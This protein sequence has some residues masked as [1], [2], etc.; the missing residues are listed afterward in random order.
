MF[1]DWRVLAHIP[2]ISHSYSTHLP[3]I[4]HSYK[5]NDWGSPGVTT[6][7][8]SKPWWLQT[9]T[10]VAPDI[11]SRFSMGWSMGW[12]DSRFWSHRCVDS[13]VNHIPGLVNVYKKQ[14][15]DPPFLMGKSTI[16]MVI[17]N[18]Y[19]KL[20]EGT[21]PGKCLQKNGKIYHFIA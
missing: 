11:A 17:F 4:F 5:I 10:V 19:V 16:S 2:F 14:W 18:S 7:E 13:L 8:I 3:F 12:S 15:K 21:R 6:G 1:S 20:P 9:R